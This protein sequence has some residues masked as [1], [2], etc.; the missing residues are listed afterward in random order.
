MVDSSPVQKKRNLRI[1]EKLKAADS[2]SDHDHFQ[3][4]FDQD[5]Q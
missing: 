4:D 5:R 2:V 1:G 3:G